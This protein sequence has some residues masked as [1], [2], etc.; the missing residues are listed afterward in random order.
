[1]PGLSVRCGH[2]VIHGIRIE[3]LRGVL[4]AFPKLIAQVL[5]PAV[6][7]ILLL[8]SQMGCCGKAHDQGSGQGAGPESRLLTSPPLQRFR[9][10]WKVF[11]RT[12]TRSFSAKLAESG[13]RWLP[14][15]TAPI[16]RSMIPLGKPQFPLSL[17]ELN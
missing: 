4:Q 3:Q 16:D 8:Q 10:R 15:I 14:A 13:S 6:A 5:Q 1:M 12:R 9:L 2:A 11:V 7:Q 17:K